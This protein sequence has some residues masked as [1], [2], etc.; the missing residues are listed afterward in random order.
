MKLDRVLTSYRIGDV[1]G[2]YPIYDAYVSTQSPGRWNTVAH[3]MIYTAQNYSAAMLEKLVHGSGTMPPNQY[4]ITITIPNGIEYETVTKD[5]LPGWQSPDCL[6]AK[7][8]GDLWIAQRRTAILIVPSVVARME[9]NLLINPAHAEAAGISH[10][11]PEPIWWD[12]RL[13]TP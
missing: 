8:F 13:F 2:A 7:A 3:P 4:F 5:T 11:L 6:A 12:G 1:N 9:C 10:T